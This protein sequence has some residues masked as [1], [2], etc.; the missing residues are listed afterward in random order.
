MRLATALLLIVVMAATAATATADVRAKPV[1]LVTGF[2]P[3]AGR[4][5]NGS[6][7]LANALDKTEIAGAIVQTVI[8]PVQWGEPTRA[9]PQQ[10]AACH[11]IAILGLGE[12][13]PDAIKVEA[14]AANRAI[15]V[16]DNAGHLPVSD[17]LAANGPA[18]LSARFRLDLT[19]KV[20][21]PVPLK[22]SRNAGGYLCNE[23]LFAIASTTVPVA[24][25]I[26]VPPQGDESD[27]VYRTR[28]LP[29]IR[30]LIRRN[31]EEH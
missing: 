4:T 30:E 6:S 24:G 12:G 9:I 16:A 11:P 23:A 8:L 27:E 20:S 22:H 19:W 25:F 10:V 26:H 1:I 3:F 2:A 15:P 17:R 29:L 13:H 31:L 7:T 28:I 14:I 21:S 5:V 18:E